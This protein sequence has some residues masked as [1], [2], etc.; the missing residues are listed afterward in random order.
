VNVNASTQNQVNNQH[1]TQVKARQQANRRNQNPV[2]IS[3][4]TLNPVDISSNGTNVPEKQVRR[5]DST[6]L[7][8]PL[9]L[10][11]LT[12]SGVA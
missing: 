6:K 9:P 10:N 7:S 3:D 11:N 4:K 12:S 2:S 8:N 5:N 1:P